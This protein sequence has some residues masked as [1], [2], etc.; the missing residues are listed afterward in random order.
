MAVV[1]ADAYGHGV[2]KVCEFIESDVA[3]FAVNDVFEAIE[4]RDNGIQKPILV[5]GVPDTKT[6]PLYEQYKITTTVSDFSH[7]ELLAEGTEY[8]VNIDTGMGRI[9]FSPR[10]AEEVVQR[11]KQKST[12]SCTGIYSHFATADEPG[13]KK[14]QE[15]LEIF[16]E[17]R[18]AFPSQLL[19][20][21]SNTG[22]TLFY[23]DAQFDMVRNG[24][25]MYGYPPG[26]TGVPEFNPALSWRSELSAVK[27]I[28]KGHT[29]SYGA[30]WRSENACYIGILP[31]GYSDGVRRNLTGDLQVSIEGTRY[32]VVG[33]IT[34]NYC[35][36]NLKDQTFPVGTEVEVLGSSALTAGDW[37]NRINTIPYEIL[38]GIHPEIPRTYSP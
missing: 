20:H 17:V 8:H 32:D 24:I 9:G 22:G 25:G 13:S 3:W 15:Q 33:T 14:V 28:P 5:F 11:I 31:V 38:T 16:K 6:A 36:V 4:L 1:K 37:A 10:Q 26:S 30:R 35:M 2:L 12:L 34:M 29:V 7:F 18:T 23:P 21:L 19:T 27:K